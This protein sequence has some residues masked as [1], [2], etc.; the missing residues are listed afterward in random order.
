MGA[1]DHVDL[2]KLSEAME[3]AGLDNDFIRWTL[4]FLIDRRVSFIID[5]YKVSEQ[6]IDL[7]LP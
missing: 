5:G 3:A 1:F 2:Y 4:S 6:S 7:G